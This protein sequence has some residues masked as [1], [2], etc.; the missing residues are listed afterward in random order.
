MNAH[1]QKQTYPEFSTINREKLSQIPM[2]SKRKGHS[3]E[4]ATAASDEMAFEESRPKTE[5]KRKPRGIQAER[6]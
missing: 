2:K 4:P 6:R 3:R 1:Q 5:R